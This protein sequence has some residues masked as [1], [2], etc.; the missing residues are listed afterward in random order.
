M[1]TRRS[2]GDGGLHWDEQR[3]RWIASVTVGYTPAGK[4]IV[5]KASGKS[6]TEAREKLKEIIRDYDDGVSVGPANYTVA[7]A[8]QDW[9]AFGLHGRDQATVTTCTHLANKHVIPCLGARKLRE[10]SAEDVDRW[11]V[12]RAKVLS[13]RSVRDVRS[14]LK[15]AVDRAQARDKVKRNVVLLSE[16][17][18]G[19]EGRPSKSLDYDQAA[20]ILDAAEK[21]HM[22]A[23][24]VLSLLLGAR[25]EELRA[26][27][28]SHVDMD[29]KRDA[30]PPV[31]PSIMVWRSVR[32]GGDT[33]T[34]K[35]RR[36]LALPK[37]CVEALR[38][39][40]SQQEIARKRAGDDWH[41]LDLVFATR[42]GTEL[43]AGNVRRAFRTVLKKTDINPDDWTPR[44]MRHSFVSLLSDDG[45]PLEHIS[46]LVGHGNTMVTET[47]YRKQL[48]PVMLEGA[49][50]MD[51]IFPLDDSER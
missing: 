8:V 20:A 45:V 24:I 17:P 25:T 16:I 37:R 47:V 3:E 13:T 22:N 4:R 43:D 50:A 49:Q 35:S 28:W 7:D 48:R 29:G 34:R 2:R 19:Q 10:L 9:L 44:E 30:T 36:T 6:K 18:K 12:D 14:V 39:H 15:R 32:E 42:H 33:K 31:P 41:D 23:Y 40:R 5:R 51:R 27:T 26:L 1:T 21:T 46:R 11:L 38:R